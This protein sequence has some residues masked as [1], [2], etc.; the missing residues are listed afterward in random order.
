[1]SDA[2]RSMARKRPTVQYLCCVLKGPKSRRKRS[3]CEG[4]TEVKIV[5][6]EKVSFCLS[7]IT[8]P[9]RVS[10]R[11][12]PV[13][14]PGSRIGPNPR[15]L[16]R[17]RRENYGGLCQGFFVANCK[18]SNQCAPPKLSLIKPR[19]VTTQL[20]ESVVRSDDDMGQ[21]VVVIVPWV[22]NAN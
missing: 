16:A 11:W 10:C 20:V 13:H 3:T 18:H 14:S 4:F 7:S 6:W 15:K 22:A 17:K 21:Y 12:P 19:I 5:A 9:C 1:M 8:S 2:Q